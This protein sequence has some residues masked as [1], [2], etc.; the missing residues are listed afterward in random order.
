MF[1]RRED[2]EIGREK[3]IQEFFGG[4]EAIEHYLEETMKWVRRI[5][6]YAVNF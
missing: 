4:Y 6:D 5:I 2:C 3:E 1:G